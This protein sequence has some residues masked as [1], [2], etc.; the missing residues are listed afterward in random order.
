M[1]SSAASNI[2][3]YADASTLENDD[4]LKPLTGVPNEHAIQEGVHLYQISGSYFSQVAR[5]VLGEKG[6]PYERHNI[7]ILAGLFDQYDPDYVRINPRCVV[8]TLVNEGK[9]SS[10]AFNIMHYVDKELGTDESP[11]L[12]PTDPA[13][14]AK[15]DELLTLVD[16]EV[17]IEAI[18]YTKCS[19]VPDGRPFFMK[20]LG[21]ETNHLKKVKALDELIEKY[22]DDAFLCKAYKS[23]RA[24]VIRMVD[25]YNSEENME[26][27][28]KKTQ[29]AFKKLATQLETG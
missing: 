18:S 29:M 16:K 9:V 10:D 2:D 24:L 22:K 25:S 27:V 21:T 17:F 26:E 5:Y 12:T 11:V 1:S 8:P 3:P 13:E 6:I 14:K 20:Q 19:A 28:W 7:L 15:M 23:K 4:I